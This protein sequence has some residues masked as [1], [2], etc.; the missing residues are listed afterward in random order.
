M[1]MNLDHI[2]Y[3]ENNHLPFVT[4]DML[5]VSYRN[6]KGEAVLIGNIN[7]LIE[8]LTGDDMQLDVS[9]TR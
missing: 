4:Y 3:D 7:N 1:P 2:R 9:K 8:G 6:K 5:Q